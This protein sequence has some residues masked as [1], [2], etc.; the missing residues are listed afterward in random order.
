MKNFHSFSPNSISGST[1]DR[2]PLV[3]GD[4]GAQIRIWLKDSDCS[5]DEQPLDYDDLTTW[6]ALDLTDAVRVSMYFRMEDTIDQA[7]QLTCAMVAPF[8]DG[9]CICAFPPEFLDDKSGDAEAEIEVE[10]SDGQIT[11]VYELIK[12]SIREDFSGNG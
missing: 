7:Y 6:P 10:F 2:I 9:V 4:S 8:T 5:D 12:F 3:A 11:T 1:E